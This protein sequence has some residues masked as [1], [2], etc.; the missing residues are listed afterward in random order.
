VVQPKKVTVKKVT[1]AKP[2][3]AKQ[4]SRLVNVQAWPP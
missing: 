3:F 2:N 4:F 1:Q